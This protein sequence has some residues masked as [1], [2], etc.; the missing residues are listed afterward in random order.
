MLFDS[1]DS[2]V[3]VT[4]TYVVCHYVDSWWQTV[5]LA[6][7]LMTQR[8]LLSTNIE[9]SSFVNSRVCLTLWRKTYW[10]KFS[11]PTS[12]CRHS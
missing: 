3:Q 10:S 4:I 8:L 2:V 9:L 11:C 7:T 5:A 1:I 12:Q 6:S